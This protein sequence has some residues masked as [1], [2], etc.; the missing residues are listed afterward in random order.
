LNVSLV[1]AWE[2]SLRVAP[3]RIQYRSL[4]ASKKN[5]AARLSQMRDL[6]AGANGIFRN[7]RFPQATVDGAEV[8]LRIRGDF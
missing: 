2:R 6:F 7:A 1:L 8:A 4:A 3:Q 5:A